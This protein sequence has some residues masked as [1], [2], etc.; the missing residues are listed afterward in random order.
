MR[1]LTALQLVLALGCLLQFT[2][3][4]VNPM[5]GNRNFTLMSEADEMPKGQSRYRDKQGI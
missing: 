5:T 4:V 1:I 2:G 3:C